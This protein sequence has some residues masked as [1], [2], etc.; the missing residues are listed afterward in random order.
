VEATAVLFQMGAS[1]S[2][3]VV[4]EKTAT[5]QGQEDAYIHP[6]GSPENNVFDSPEQR[7]LDERR[8]EGGF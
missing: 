5:R 7:R 3:Q 2:T 6:G 4:S 8:S 1:E